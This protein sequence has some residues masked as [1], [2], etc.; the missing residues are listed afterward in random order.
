[1]TGT[2]AGAATDKV[3]V[4]VG[5]T[6]PISL[7]GV[8]SALRPRPELTLVREG[9]GG[10][11]GAR[12]AVIVTDRVDEATMRAVRNARRT[13]DAQVVLVA[14]YLTDDDVVAAVEAGVLALVRRSEATP[15]RL[16][17]VIRSAAHGEGTVPPDLLGHLL[18]QVG[19]LQRQV[20]R[21]RGLTF[22]GLATREIDVLRLV[23]DGMDTAEIARTLSYSERTVKN[24][25][26][27]ITTRLQLRNRS[28]AVAYALREGL[29]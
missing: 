29:I 12:V 21:P 15:D 11:A 18:D 14:G 16:V 25:L 27:D 19:S 13:G 8:A 4:W 7:A 10:A 3:R 2:V 17:A 9:D 5:A 20:L 23:A 22:T 26:H 6:D 24:V 1:M 28:H